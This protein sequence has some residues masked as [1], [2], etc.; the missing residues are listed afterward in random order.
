MCLTIITPL[1]VHRAHEKRVKM[2]PK[3]PRREAEF[4]T[5]TEPKVTNDGST[6]SCDQELSN[7]VL[8][9]VCG[10]VMVAYS[11]LCWHVLTFF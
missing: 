9:W 1:V 2:Y 10:E 4:S 11:S 8:V 7:D 6:E 3:S 5:D